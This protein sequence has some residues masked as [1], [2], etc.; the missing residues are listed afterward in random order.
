MT[1]ALAYLNGR[2][3]PAS[4]ARLAVFDAGVVLGA[5]VSELIRTFQHRLYR[6]EDHLDRLGQSLK[7]MRLEIGLSRDDVI[8]ACNELVAHNAGLQ[9]EDDELGLVAFVTAGEYPTYAGMSGRA[10]RTAPTVCFHTFPLPFDLWAEKMLSGAALV[11]PSVRHIPPECLDP[12]MKCRSRMHFYLADREARALDPGATALLL[13][14]AGHVTET[15]T[16]NFL[17]IEG[18]ALVSPDRRHILPGISRAVVLD[19][20]GKLSLPVVERAISIVEAQNADEAFLTSTP[21]CMLPVTRING[22]ALGAGRPGP[23]FRRLLAAWSRAVGLDIEK[24]IVAGARK[25]RGA[26]G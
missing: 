19:L 12:G 2:M 18:G 4:E 26:A 22:V 21:Y 15:A 25:R 13:D 3:M 16:A 24:Q 17:M 23:L 10:A 14:L 9:D 1:E 7:T 20:A 6:F 11:V 8:S 5:T